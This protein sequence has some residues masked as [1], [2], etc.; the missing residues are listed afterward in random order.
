MRASSDDAAGVSRA[1][2]GACRSAPSTPHFLA[3]WVF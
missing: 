2:G 3:F 1:D